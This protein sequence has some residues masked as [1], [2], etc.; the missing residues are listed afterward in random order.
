[1]KR[2]F[3]L[4]QYCIPQHLLSRLIGYLAQSETIWFKNWLINSF[5]N[6]YNVD[7]SLAEKPLSTDYIHFNDFFTRPLKENARPIC[8]GTTIACPADGAI[9]EM[10]NIDS[11]TIMQAKG[12]RYTTAALLGSATAAKAYEDGQFMTVYLS[13]KDYH[14]V[15]IPMA[16]T[17]RCTRYIP[18]QLFSVNQTTADNV[19]NV[20]ARNERLV[21]EFDTEHGPMTVVLVGAMIVAGISTVWD[22]DLK[23]APYTVLETLFEE[24]APHFEKGDEI[25]RFY[26]GSTAIV[27][28]PK[29]MANWSDDLNAQSKVD[30]GQII[31]QLYKRQ[32]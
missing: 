21:C 14:R 15:H 19:D 27:L 31:G 17:L 2:V 5:I 4:L 1:M 20:F 23:P 16:G 18:G 9:S 30:M 32:D 28:L 8:E 22:K 29:G 24:N 3:I 25:G 10:G 6:T 7:M 11:N 13:P 26:L 12:K